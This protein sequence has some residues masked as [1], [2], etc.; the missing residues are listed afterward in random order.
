MKLF[1]LKDFFCYAD[2]Q[3]E[4]SEKLKRLFHDIDIPFNPQDVKECTAELDFDK[5]GKGKNPGFYQDHPN[6]I[7][8]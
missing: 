4:A 1:E 2:T 8:K 6:N 3:N 5:I 7:L